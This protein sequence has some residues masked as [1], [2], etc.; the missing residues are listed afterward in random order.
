MSGLLSLP[1]PGETT[2]S[3]GLQLKDLGPIVIN[4][5]GSTSRITNW[6]QMTPAEQERVMIRIPKRNE[7]RRA[8][9]LAQNIEIQINH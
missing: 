3:K 5:D 7:E 1:A 6:S 2:A 8:K 4:E 9:L